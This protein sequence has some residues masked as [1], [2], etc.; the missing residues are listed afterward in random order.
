MKTFSGYFIT[1]EGGE[2]AGKTTLLNQLAAFL[3]EQGYQVVVTREPGGTPLGEAIRNWLL[4]RELPMGARAELLLFLAARAQQIEEKIRPALEAGKVVLCDRFNDSTIAYQGGARG[5]GV[6]YVRQLCEL[7]CG[8]MIPQ[9]TLLLTV[10]P[11]VGLARSRRRS[12]EQA[13]SGQLD[14]IESESLEFH[15]TLQ[16]TLE[17]LAEQESTRIHTLDAMRP[18]HWVYNEAVRIIQNIFKHSG[19]SEEK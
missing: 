10:P 17:R 14:R 12:N 16:Q 1:L 11:E 3:A 9:L 4:G 2:G 19:G 18:Q 8:S 5:L 7:V 6:G 13:P 15:H